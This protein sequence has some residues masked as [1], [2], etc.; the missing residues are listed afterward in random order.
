M[1]G[2]LGGLGLETARWL[3]DRGAGRLILAGRRPP[4]ATARAALGRITRRG[5]APICV[6]GDIGDPEDA[7]RVFAAIEATGLDLAGVV[8]SA[9]ALSD[10]SLLHQDWPRFEAVLRAKV[11]GAWNLHRLTRSRK[12]DF[13]VLYSSGASLLG[14]IG[15][16]NHAAANAFMDSLAFYR[17]ARSL[18]ALSVNWAAWRDV[19]AAAGHGVLDRARSEGVDPI[20]IGGG[21][22]ALERLIAAGAVQTAV[23][24]IDWTRLDGQGKPIFRDI[25]VRPPATPPKQDTPGSRDRVKPVTDGAWRETLDDNPPAMRKST[26]RERLE[27]TIAKTLRLRS[28]QSIDPHQPLQDLGLDSLVALQIRNTIAAALAI[29][30]PPTVL[31]TY[32]TIDQLAEHLLLELYGEARRPTADSPAAPA[33]DT[34]APALMGGPTVLDPTSASDLLANLDQLSDSEIETLLKT[35]DLGAETA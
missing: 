22:R 23:L 31:Y 18:P 5:H 13:F 25:D 12:L 28:F 2:G 34:G 32:P 27:A 10:A 30:L 4:D 14:S 29:R 26:L 6:A 21:L 7:D 3:A 8:H 15:Q 16:A 24:P 35:I 20:D 1:T 17:R 9:G 11:A 33:A 19:G